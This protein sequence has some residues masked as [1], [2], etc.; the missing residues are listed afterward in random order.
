MISSSFALFGKRAQYSSKHNFSPKRH[1]SFLVLQ[2][3][4]IKAI[5]KTHFEFIGTVGI[6]P[7][8]SSG[9]SKTRVPKQPE[10]NDTILEH[11]WNEQFCRLCTSRASRQPVLECHSIDSLLIRYGAF[12]DRFSVSV[13]ASSFAQKCT[14]QFLHPAQRSC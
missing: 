3:S 6:C 4:F 12:T 14:R 10:E 11:Q 9:R 8:Q 5:C 7:R 1:A 2:Y 13:K